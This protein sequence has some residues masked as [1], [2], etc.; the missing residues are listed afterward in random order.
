L[1]WRKIQKHFS[2]LLNGLVDELQNTLPKD[3]TEGDLKAFEEALR[4]LYASFPGKRL[5]IETE[6]EKSRI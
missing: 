4:A 2:A 5:A 3:D 1:I 6:F